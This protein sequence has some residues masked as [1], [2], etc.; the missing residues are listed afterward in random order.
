MCKHMVH[1]FMCVCL[2]PAHRHTLTPRTL[3]W[4]SLFNF[5]EVKQFCSVFVL[6]F[7][8]GHCCVPVTFISQKK[9]INIKAPTTPEVL[10][11]CVT[12]FTLSSSRGSICT[13]TCSEEPLNSLFT[14]RAVWESFGC[15]SDWCCGFLWLPLF[16]TWGS[17]SFPAAQYNIL[18]VIS[19]SLSNTFLFYM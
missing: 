10:V 9:Y 6:W 1:V 2:K 8:T 13:S 19:P 4:N 3:L 14:I 17:L 18:C 7:D 15:F 11:T 5:S 12:L 16:Y